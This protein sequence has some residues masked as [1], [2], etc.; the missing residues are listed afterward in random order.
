M[1][2]NAEKMPNSLKNQ[3]KPAVDTGNRSAPSWSPLDGLAVCPRCLVSV[4]EI[5]KKGTKYEFYQH[6]NI[7]STTPNAVSEFNQF[8]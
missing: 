1:K 4:I 2:G 6:N 8:T 3:Q 5:D 7:R